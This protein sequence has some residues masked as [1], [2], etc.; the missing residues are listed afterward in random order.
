MRFRRRY[1]EMSWSSQFLAVRPSLLFC[2]PPCVLRLTG[3]LYILSSWRSG[4]FS[5]CCLALDSSSSFPCPAFRAIAK[6]DP[7][8]QEVQE[9]AY[10]EFD[11][12]IFKQKLTTPNSQIP[13]EFSTDSSVYMEVRK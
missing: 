6:S 7:E 12:M 8:K 3:N 11:Q 13:K 10:L 5:S 1:R 9:V 2:L 4:V